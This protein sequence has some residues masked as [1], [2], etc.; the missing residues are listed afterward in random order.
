MIAARNPGKNCRLPQKSKPTTI[1]E[2]AIR[3][4][5]ALCSSRRLQPTT[6]PAVNMQTEHPTPANSHESG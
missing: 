5:Q 3:K 6:P 1:V 2:R 4:K